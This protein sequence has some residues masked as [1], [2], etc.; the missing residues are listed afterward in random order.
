[1]SAK[2][3]PFT[4][5][6]QDNEHLTL[7]GQNLRQAVA[8]PSR[9]AELDLLLQIGG[10]LLD[11]LEVHKAIDCWLVRLDAWEERRDSH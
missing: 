4:P 8:V 1:M 6:K 3:I 10:K 9:D 2:I 7:T 11:N 5:R